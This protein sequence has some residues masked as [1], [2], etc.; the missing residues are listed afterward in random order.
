MNI[1]KRS[2][3]LVDKTVTKSTRVLVAYV[4]SKNM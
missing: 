4:T 3:G 1:N 2:I